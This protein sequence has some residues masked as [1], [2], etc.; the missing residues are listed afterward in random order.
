M[1]LPLVTLTLLAAL[2]SYSSPVRAQ[3][4]TGELQGVVVD[5]AGAAVTGATVTVVNT[6]TGTTRELRAD[7]QGRFA[8]PGLQVG[9][10]EVTASESRFAPR[11]QE[12]LHLPLGQIVTLRLELRAAPLPETLTIALAP[13]TIDRA[14]AHAS[15]LIEEAALMHLPTKGRDFLDL[16]QTVPGVTRDLSTGAPVLAGQ[17]GTANTVFVDGGE[18]FGLG[19]YQFSQDAIKELRIDVNAYRAEYGRASGGVLHA[20]TKSGTNR[21]HGSA[22]AFR[23]VSGFSSD[24]SGDTSQ[25]AGVVGGPI[26][27][28][29]HFFLVNY[30]G[31]RRRDLDRDQRVFLARTDHA[32]GGSNRLMARYNDQ[33][34]DGGSSY[35][36][37]S[38][39]SSLTSAL[40]S[41][42]VNDARVHYAEGRGALSIDRLQFAD[43][44]AWVGGAHEI[45]AGIDGRTDEFAGVENDEV[46]T[47]VQD[48]WRA[49]RAM[50]V[51][52]GVRREAGTVDSWDPRAGV[53]WASAGGMVVRGSYGRFFGDTHQATAGVEKEVMP[54]M[55]VAANFLAGSSDAWEYRALTGEIQ[56]R[57]WLGTLFR[58]AYTLGRTEDPAGN[59][60]P[61]DPRHRFVA[62]FVYG[63]NAFAARFG[64][65]VETILTDW[66]VSGISTLQSG[67][68]RVQPAPIAYSSFDP[69]IARNIALGEGRTLALI[70]ESYNMRDR[71]NF[72]VTDDPF[73]PQALGQ[74]QGRLTQVAARFAF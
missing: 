52:I 59:R 14:Q 17:M 40:G 19:P 10:Y 34:F 70:L 18:L 31:L 16:A 55:T 6:G 1:K 51:N 3:A 46:S 69:R 49:T 23:S 62:S 37:R 2:L 57:F 11:R 38:F 29:K 63:T 5:E 28:D 36:T 21:F 27:Q 4:V 48:Q 15:A 24:G 72:M 30:D 50:T 64:G 47:F 13:S 41:R 43:T 25:F 71:P 33:D 44:I 26:A 73:F 56:Q 32:I 67:D 53:T 9:W 58:G 60:A 22:S 54:R 8:A 35:S 65:L 20:I 7:D 66:T 74:R 12:G 45:K 61:H 39:V 68:A 42:F